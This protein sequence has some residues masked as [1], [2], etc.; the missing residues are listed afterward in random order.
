MRPRSLAKE[1]DGDPAHLPVDLD[2]GEIV[3]PVSTLHK[4]PVM[5]LSAFRASPEGFC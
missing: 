5:M 2:T 1:V 4:R 3:S